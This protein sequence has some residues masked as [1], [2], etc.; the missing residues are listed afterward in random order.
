MAPKPRRYPPA[1]SLLVL[2]L[3]LALMSLP[4]TIVHFLNLLRPT[5]NAATNFIVNSTGDNGDSNLGDGVCND[6]TGA[7]TLRAAISEANA[8]ASADV[9]TFNLPANSII[10]LNNTLD[11]ITEDLDINGP[12]ANTLT[13]QRSAAGGSPRFGIFLFDNRNKTF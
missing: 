9:I 11:L 5:A 13:V 6:G 12:G 10:T 1:R 3:P 2:S 4:S 8:D 7:C